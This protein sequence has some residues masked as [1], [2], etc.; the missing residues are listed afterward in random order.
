MKQHTDAVLDAALVWREAVI[1]NTSTTTYPQHKAL[2]EAIDAYVAAV[3]KAESDERAY[4]DGIWGA[5]NW[6]ECDCTVADA[7]MGC[8]HHKNLH[9]RERP[10]WPDHPW[11]RTTL[12][13]FNP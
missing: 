9:R 8:R 11:P 5:G 3:D 12:V 4:S 13:T 10:Q 7:G 6:I 1:P 2:V